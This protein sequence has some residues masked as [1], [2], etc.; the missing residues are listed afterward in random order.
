[1]SGSRLIGLTTALT[2][3]I[4][5]LSKDADPNV[6]FSSWPIGRLR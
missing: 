2:V 5:R 3:S 6:I 4:M 1:M